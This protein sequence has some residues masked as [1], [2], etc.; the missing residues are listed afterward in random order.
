MLKIRNLIY[1]NFSTNLYHF[2]II[3]VCM[4]PTILKTHKW[5]EFCLFF[6]FGGGG[7]KIF[8]KHCFRV[9]GK[10][11]F[12]RNKPSV[13]T[14]KFFLWKIFCFTSDPKSGSP[15]PQKKKKTQ[16]PELRKTPNLE[17]NRIFYPQLS[18]INK[19]NI[20]FFTFPLNLMVIRV[21]WGKLGFFEFEKKKFK[22]IFFNFYF[23]FKNFSLLPENFERVLTTWKIVG[24]R[25]KTTKKYVWKKHFWKIISNSK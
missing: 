13:L 8:K 23:F 24:K 4:F 18:K 20:D 22:N 9:R 19:I 12:G 10:K 16:F 25:K 17:G 3:L 7:S 6:F 21:F 5:G 14:S 15:P 11:L 1:M 2:F